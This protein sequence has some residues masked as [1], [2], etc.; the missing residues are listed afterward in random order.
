MILFTQSFYLIHQS[1]PALNKTHSVMQI[2]LPYV[3][4][5][6]HNSH[7]SAQK[8]F[9]FGCGHESKRGGK[10]IISSSHS[11]Q[12]LMWLENDRTYFNAEK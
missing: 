7:H 5:K 1:T 11:N 6:H 3:Q 2:P 9:H 4:M 12:V 8:L 10:H